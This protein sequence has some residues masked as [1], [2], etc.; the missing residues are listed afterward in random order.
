MVY[1]SKKQEIDSHLPDK[2]TAVDSM[3]FAFAIGNC[4]H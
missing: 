3:L 2:L 1:S 4:Q